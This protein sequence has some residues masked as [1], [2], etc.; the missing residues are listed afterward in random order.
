MRKEFIA[1]IWVKMDAFHLRQILWNLLLNAAEAIKGAGEIHIK[2]ERLR[3]KL[4]SIAISDNGCGMTQE[5]LGSIFD[6][7]FTTKQKG[8][9][10]GLSIVHSILESYKS[11]PEVESRIGQGSKFT[12]K[13]SQIEAPT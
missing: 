1:D 9:G 13:F 2:M 8:T 11:R 7:F 6:P 10:L 5:T 4:V 3:N 12:L